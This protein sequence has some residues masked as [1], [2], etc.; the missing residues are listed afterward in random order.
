MNVKNKSRLSKHL[1]HYFPEDKRQLYRRTSL[2]EGDRDQNIRLAYNEFAY[3]N[4]E[5]TYK[6]GDRSHKKGQFSIACT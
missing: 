4:T 6:L 1:N 2:C 5:D 3:K